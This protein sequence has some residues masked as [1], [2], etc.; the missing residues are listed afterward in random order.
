MLRVTVIGSVNATYAAY[1][2]CDKKVK[3]IPSIFPEGPET[4]NPLDKNLQ[5]EDSEN[6]VIQ[7]I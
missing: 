5:H 1:H 7:H 2:D 6:A 4:I 3:D